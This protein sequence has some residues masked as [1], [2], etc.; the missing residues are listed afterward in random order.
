[1]SLSALE[2]VNIYNLEVLDG[3]YYCKNKNLISI[4]CNKIKYINCDIYFRNYSVS[5]KKSKDK[6]KINV[7]CVGISK[8][9]IYFLN[10]LPNNIDVLEIPELI[11][12]EV[13]L[14]LPV[15]LKKLVIINYYEKNIHLMN[16]LLKYK[17]PYDTKIIY[18]IKNTIKY[19][20]NFTYD[21]LNLMST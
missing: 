16:I 9:L 18:K 13:L 21:K 8:D 10:D 20:V 4:I 6:L 15:N 14:N 7:F 11:L 3:D 1:M 5:I 2:H 19:N 12:N 17:I